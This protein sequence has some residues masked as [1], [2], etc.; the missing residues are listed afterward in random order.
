V[1]LLEKNKKTFVI[2]GGGA[3]GLFSAITAAEQDPEAQVII[4]EKSSQLLIKL[5]LSGGGRCNVTHSAFD[6][7]VLVQHYPRGHKELLGPFHRFQPKDTVEWF[8]KRNVPLKT[9]GDGRMF[10]TTDSSETIASCFLTEAKRLNVDIRLEQKIEKI[11]IKEDGFEICFIQGDRLPCHRL[12][13]ATGSSPQGYEWART[14]G[15][16]VT[17]PVP[18]LFTFNV[19]SSPLLDLSGIAVPDAVVKIQGMTWKQRGPLLIT[20]WGFSGPAALKLSAWAARDLN[21]R[22]YRVELVV[23]WVPDLTLEEA[24][25]ALSDLKAKKPQKPLE[26]ESLFKLPMNLWKRLVQLAGISEQLPLSAV[27]NGKLKELAKMCTG[28]SFQVEGKTTNKQEFVTCGGVNLKEIDFKRMES[29]LVKNLFFAG[30]ILDVDG[31]TGGFNFQH[32]W[33]SGWIAGHGITE[34]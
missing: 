5:K 9:E 18:S 2:L 8:L 6:P 20:H 26:Q 3:A 1:N 10:P 12:L 19:P 13:L 16:R 34:K 17:P 29:R 15:H 32:A 7:K 24:E 22:Q 31:V 4:L 11:Q 14:F 30:E 27:S 28:H 23:Q 25:N 21:E 33:T